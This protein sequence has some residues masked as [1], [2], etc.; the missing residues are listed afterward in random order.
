MLI[1]N[2]NMCWICLTYDNK[3]VTICNCKNDF[4]IAHQMCFGKFI[5]TSKETRCRF[6]KNEYIISLKLSLII[7]FY[8][9]CDTIEYLWEIYKKT[10]ELVLDHNLIL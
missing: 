3:E 2:N 5:A 6:C 1:I 7:K 4:G 10:N 9:M 8:Y